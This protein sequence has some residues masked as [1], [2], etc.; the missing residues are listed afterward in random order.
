LQWNQTATLL[1]WNALQTSHACTQPCMSDSLTGLGVARCSP[2][3]Q[4]RNAPW[5][6]LDVSVR[7]HSCCL[8]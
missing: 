8:F 5:A 7:M 1:S 3:A 4:V 6:E 2:V